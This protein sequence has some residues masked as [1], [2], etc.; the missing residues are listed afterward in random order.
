MNN[1]TL[2]NLKAELW[3][4]FGNREYPAEWDGRVYGGG[5]LSQRFWEYFEGVELLDPSPESVVLD[6]GG[7]SPVTGAGFF[8]SLLASAVKKV[9]I[10]DPNVAADA[11]PAANIEYLGA[12][13][14]TVC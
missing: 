14:I 5:K 1:P 12:T 13:A 7:G 4:R 6:I 10:L 11:K 9:L 2:R 8:S 3:R